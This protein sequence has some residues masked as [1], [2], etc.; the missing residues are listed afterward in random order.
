MPAISGIQEIKAREKD[1]LINFLLH[2]RK[3]QESSES[4]GQVFQGPR[5]GIPSD[6]LIPV[7]SPLS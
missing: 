5:W 1:K 3:L 6:A 7:S 2:C 4:A